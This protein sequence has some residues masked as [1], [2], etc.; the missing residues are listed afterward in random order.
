MGTLV[1]NHVHR[2]LQVLLTN[3]Q[4][5]DHRYNV[6][7]FSKLCLAVEVTSEQLAP[8]LAS[9]ARDISRQF[10]KVFTLFA[11]WHNCYNSGSKLTDHKLGEWLDQ[12]CSLQVLFF[13]AT[14]INKFMTGPSF[15]QPAC[16]LKCTYWKSLAQ[17]MESRVGDNGRTGSWKHT[18][19]HHTSICKHPRQGPK[20]QVCNWRA[21]MPCTPRV[22]ANWNKE[23][24]LSELQV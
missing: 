19:H 11:N 17:E 2:C 9:T 7:I 1:G 8:S 23:G 24:P 20:T 21:P 22:C 5:H 4:C 6:H 14:D 18:Q 15:Q 13:T 3:T 10:T 12:F 16:F